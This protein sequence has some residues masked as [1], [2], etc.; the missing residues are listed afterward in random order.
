MTRRA[1][2][3]PSASA[4]TAGSSSVGFADGSLGHLDLTDSRA[5]G[6]ARGLPGLRR[7]RQRRRQQLPALVPARDARSSA[8]PPRT[9][10]TTG[11]SARTPTSGAA[12]S[13]ASP[14]RSSPARPQL[15]ASVDDGLAAMR[16]MDAI[17][18]SVET[19]ATV[20]VDAGRRGRV[21]RARHLRQ[22]VRRGPRSATTL[23]AVAAHGIDGDPVQHGRCVGGPSLPAEIATGGRR[24]GPRRGR[25]A[26][27]SRMAAVSGT[28][29]MA[30]PD[31]AV[32]RPAAR[33]LAALIA[34]APRLGTARGDAVHRHARSGR[35]VAR[36][37]R[38]RRAARR[39]ATAS[40]RSRPRSRSPSGTASTLAFEPEHANVV[41]D[42]AAGRRLLDELRSRICRS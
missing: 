42:A 17:E 35:H 24:G 28:Y 33:R 3:W 14:T 21:M 41:R 39:G 8:S 5:D 32:R 16:V 29:N 23:D 27:A 15:G 13:R 31:P 9:A 36:A 26:A 1:R 7:A 25:R 38:Q 22:D 10:S 6:L 12:R 20:R 40:S 34:A 2:A 11:R 4:R 18:R 19:G 37:S 30:H